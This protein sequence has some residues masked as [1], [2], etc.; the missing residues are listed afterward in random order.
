MSSIPFERYDEEFVELTA[1]VHAALSKVK[2]DI[3]SN[4]SSASLEANVRQASNLLTQCDDLLK[5]MSIEARGTDDII[6]KKEYLHKVRICKANLENLKDD[7]KASKIDAEH[8][9]LMSGGQDNDHAGGLSNDAKA[10]LLAT[11]D[12]L[13]RQ[14]ETLDNARRI[15]AETE[16]VALEIT[17]E[18]GRNREKIQSTH[19]RVRDVSGLTNRARRILH[20]MNRR[21]VQQ[22]LAIYGVGV[23]LFIILVFLLFK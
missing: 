17:E 15:M 14:N 23:V 3:E 20:N 12:S 1:Q 11:N 19:S 8:S 9:A 13:S 6:L 21:E 2:G 5:Q 16:D 18:L 7:Y 10:R 22:R 4:P